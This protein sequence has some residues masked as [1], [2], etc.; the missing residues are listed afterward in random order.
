MGLNKV[1]PDMHCWK[2]QFIDNDVLTCHGGAGE[3]V[4][5]ILLRFQRREEGEERRRTTPSENINISR[6][7]VP[8]WRARCEAN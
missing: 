4:L 6:K 8:C 5:R 7:Y 2:E 1:Q 3:S